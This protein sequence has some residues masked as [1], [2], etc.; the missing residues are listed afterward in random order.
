MDMTEHSETLSAQIREQ[1]KRENPTW[2][3]AMLS[4]SVKRYFRKQ[5]VASATNPIRSETRNE[6]L[7]KIVDQ[8]LQKPPNPR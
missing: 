3:D 7:A 2:S 8:G 6:E 5:T 1:L 4:E